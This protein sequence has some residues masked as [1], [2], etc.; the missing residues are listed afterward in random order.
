MKRISAILVVLVMLSMSASSFGFFLI[1]NV[2]TTVKGVSAVTGAKV[3]VPLKGY[4]VLD[5]DDSDGS[6]LDANL[7]LYGKDS[8]TPSKQKVYAQLNSNDAAGDLFAS[9]WYL[10][11][12]TFLRLEGNQPWDFEI[13]L[14]GKEKLMD[15]GFGTLNKV[16]VASSIKG[17]NMVRAGILLGPDGME[18]SGTANASA[19]LWIAA[20]KMVNRDGWTQ[21][22]IVVT[23]KDTVDGHVNS[24]IQRLEYKQYSAIVLP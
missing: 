18:M 11:D 19:T 15:I 17:V 13:L 10:G 8:N 7:I 3:T 21:D 23:G 14:S 4:L 12:Y 2:S 20:V 1:Y 6:I 24:L 16:S 9:T 22:E 5:I